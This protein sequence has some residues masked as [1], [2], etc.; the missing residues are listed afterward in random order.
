MRPTGR[1]GAPDPRRCSRGCR[2][3]L[4]GVYKGSE[5]EAKA[6]LIR[7]GVGD[8][9]PM[10]DPIRAERI[11][12]CVLGILP[13]RKHVLHSG[14]LSIQDVLGKLAH[15]DVLSSEVDRMVMIPAPIQT[16][17]F[18]STTAPTKRARARVT[19]YM[20]VCVAIRWDVVLGV[21]Y[22]VIKKARLA[23]MLGPD[24]IR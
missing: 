12:V 9:I 8:S 22:R 2:G 1:K 18:V 14:A 4:E 19:G 24:K 16:H 17:R 3:G 21:T 11:P 10:K 15:V 23:D 5:Q 6:H 7:G 20:C 13:R